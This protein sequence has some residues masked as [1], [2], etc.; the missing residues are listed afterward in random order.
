MIS[1]LKKGSGMIKHRGRFFIALFTILSMRVIVLNAVPYCAFRSQSSNSA[2]ELVGWAHEVNRFNDGLCED[3]GTVAATFEYSRSFNASGLA[4]GLIG[5]DCLTGGLDCLTDCNEPTITISGSRVENRGEKDWLADYFGLPT[6]YKSTVTLNPSIKTY[7]VDFAG[8]WGLDSWRKGLYFRFHAPVVHTRW[9][10][11]YKEGVEA[12]GVAS[13]DVGYF[14]PNLLT[15]N[16]L[17]DDFHSYVT[18]CEVPNLGRAGLSN[19]I[20]PRYPNAP[21][22]R[23][24]PLACSKWAGACD[25]VEKTALSEITLAFGWNFWQC[26]DY[27]AG[28]NIRAALPTGTRPN[29]ELFFEPV[30]GNGHHWELGVGFTGHYT[31]WRGCNDDSSMGFY[32]DANLT[33]LFRDR[34][35]RV[36]DLKGKCNSRYMLAAKLGQP[37][38]N[39]FAPDNAPSAQFQNVYTPV[40]NI[41]KAWVDVSVGIQAD[42]T[43]MFNYNKCNWNVDFGYNFW[44][45]SCEKLRFDACG[46]CQNPLINNHQWVLKGDSYMYAYDVNVELSSLSSSQSNATLFKGT[47]NFVGPDINPTSNPVA[48]I[49]GIG[50]SR[51]PGVDNVQPAYRNGP[52]DEALLD[53]SVGSEG[54]LQTHTSFDPVFLAPHDLDVCGART[55]GTSNK[56]FVFASYTWEDSCGCYIPYLGLGGSA[57]WGTRSSGCV[58]TPN[59]VNTCCDSN[60]CKGCGSSGNGCAKCALSQW[61]LWIKTGVSFD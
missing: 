35:C 31:F 60:D 23:F 3:Y 5:A 1:F 24:E 17:N 49:N 59:A 2:R 19:E 50:P 37:V 33:H 48:G 26:D 9:N 41:T 27:H 42:I 56:L 12:Q 43:L 18:G 57:E 51:N 21:I 45:R 11:D 38:E 54:D 46:E 20:N 36:F 55:K 25:R 47:N 14:S 34:Q 16:T 52:Q 13:Y 7:L 53:L 61:A 15:R 32:L 4:R 40:A 6:D 10:L 58:I 44:S 22:V 39:L 28:L 29:C 8:Y 30:V